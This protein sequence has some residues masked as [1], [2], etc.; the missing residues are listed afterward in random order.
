MTA[1]EA[2]TLVPGD[3]FANEHGYYMVVVNVPEK[4]GMIVAQLQAAEGSMPYQ[5]M[6]SSV[7]VKKIGL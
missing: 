4:G 7:V 1:V 5:E 3:T 6:Q 2:A